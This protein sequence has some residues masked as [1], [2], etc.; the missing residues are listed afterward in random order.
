MLRVEGISVA[1]GDRAALR[2]VSLAVSPGEVVALVGPNGCGKTTLI[3]AITKVVPWS[4]G[5]VFIGEAPVRTLSP[6]ELSRRVAV[7]PQ[8]PQ[9]PVGYTALEAVL[10]GRTPHL[11][12]LDQ[13]G[14]EDYRSSAAALE[15]VGAAHLAQRHVDELSGGERQ[16]VVLARALAQDAPILLL[17]EPTANLDIG[18][19]IKAARLVRNL[20]SGGL[21][22]L[23]AVHDLTLA[24]LYSDRIILMTDGEVIAS[25]TPED[26]LTAESL[27]AAYDAEV[28]VL[29]GVI[30]RPLVVPI[31]PA[32]GVG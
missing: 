9:L 17:D 13:E 15:R 12:F 23:A 32:D 27:R 24:S 28:T 30:E 2:N 4:S 6:R 16:N 1:Y 26:V 22:V 11:A 8:N 20:A 7:V 3:K 14:A 10:M 29:R 18:H 25:G 31:A 5:Q 21:A 19:Q